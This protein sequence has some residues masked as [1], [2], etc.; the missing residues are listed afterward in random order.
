MDAQLLLRRAVEARI[1]AWDHPFVDERD[2]AAAEVGL[3]LQAVVREQLPQAVSAYASLDGMKELS[4][5]TDAEQRLYILGAFYVL[6]GNRDRM[7][8][9]EADLSVAP[10][11]ASMV[12]VGGV[13]SVFEMPTGERQFVRRMETVRWAHRLT[14]QLA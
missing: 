1:E 10:G 9:V 2:T 12:R 7:L 4:A 8:P 14:L 6:G 3:M 5:H 11:T 13:D